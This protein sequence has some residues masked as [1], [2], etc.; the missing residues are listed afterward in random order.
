MRLADGLDTE[1]KAVGASKTKIIGKM[2]FGNALMIF[3]DR[4]KKAME[5]KDGTK[6]PFHF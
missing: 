6:A 3:Q 1:H 5:I 2:T 4:Q